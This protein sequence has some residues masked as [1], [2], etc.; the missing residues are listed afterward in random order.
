M[1][2][3]ILEWFQRTRL[4]V[5]KLP[6][7]GEIKTKCPYCGRENFYFSTTKKVGLCHHAKCGRTVTLADLVKLVGFGP[8]IDLAFV[9]SAREEEKEPE[10]EIVLDHPPVVVSDNGEY[11]THYPNVVSYLHGRGL[12]TQDIL[13]FDIR[14]DGER[15]YLPIRDEDGILRQY[16]SR[17][18]H[19]EGKKYKYASGVDCTQFLLGWSECRLWDKLC[20]VENSFVSIWLRNH[21]QCTTPFG[22]NLSDRQV[23]L[24]KHSNI[25]SVAIMFDEGADSRAAKAVGKL[26][27]VGVPSSFGMI[28]GQPDDHSLSQ[29]VEWVR[30]L[31][32]ATSAGT[33][34]L[35]FRED[36]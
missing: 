34:R 3:R 25:R 35:N 22:S 8:E 32:L 28:R 2:S 29:V 13:R 15:I 20:L 24:I 9:S 6:G 7:R 27:R 18:L 33:D 31:Q 12:S 10:P 30:L 23:D 4:G 11:N 14:F 36:K 1:D 17:L 21:V 26:R 19:G 5:D 16:N